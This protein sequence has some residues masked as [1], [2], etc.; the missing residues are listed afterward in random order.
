M[1]LLDSKHRGIMFPKAPSTEIDW[2]KLSLKG[3]DQTSHVESH[4][5]VE[6]GQ[7]SAPEVVASPYL[8]VHGLSPALNYGQQCYEG[9][10]ACR[11]EDNRILLFRPDRH[12][13]RMLHSTSTV[14][15]PNIPEDHFLACVNLVV[16]AN[17]A[18]VPP[19]D[20]NA[21]LYI[22]PLAFGSG[23]QLALTSP[24]EFTFAVFT[25]PGSA[26]H[27]VTAQNALV[28]EDFDR[29]APLGVGS[30]KVGG[31]YAP[32]MKYTDRAYRDGFPLLLH[33]DSLTHTEIDEFSTSGFLGVK[34]GEKQHT[35]IV[36]QSR[37]VLPSVT[38]DSCVQMA[39]RFGWK[40]EKRAVKF[41]EV[42]F[43]DEVMAVGTATLLL[44][45]KSI[46]YTSKDEKITFNNE[47][48]QGGPCCEALR[49]AI[50]DILRGRA[51]GPEGWS[52]P[53]RE[54]LI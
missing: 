3:L 31:N 10:K 46:T 17:S 42:R 14:S 18:Y 20:S 23:P 13:H 2:T 37:N 47:S 15:I 30:A 19:H 6:T 16:A 45:I 21:L 36:P 52:V 9:L 1:T 27:G 40:V 38:A 44:P 33:L 12:A 34:H 26:Y 22:R 4:Y 25:L 29:T 43:F 11:T 50:D 49:N 48:S 28:C 24:S 39:E 53:V 5:S 41:D 32:A 54:V 7:W 51:E 35:L 8:K